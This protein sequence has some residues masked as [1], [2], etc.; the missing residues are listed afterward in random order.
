[1]L[2]LLLYLFRHSSLQNLLFAVHGVKN[3]PLQSASPPVSLDEL[4]MVRRGK[5]KGFAVRFRLINQN[6]QN[7][8]VS[9]TLVMV[10]KNEDLRNPIYRVIPDMP[11]NKGLPLQP[12]KGRGFEV[13]E[14]IFVF[15]KFFHK[16]HGRLNHSN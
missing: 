13:K 15:G 3:M 5:Q 1:M 12:E 11:L 16:E 6:Q 10:A 4:K 14:K 9:G 2:L 7:G 8:A